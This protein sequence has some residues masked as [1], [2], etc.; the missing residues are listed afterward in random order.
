[1]QLT[2]PEPRGRDGICKSVDDIL[3]ATPTPGQLEEKIEA[4]LKVCLK[5]S[6][7]LSPSKFQCAC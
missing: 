2:K 6:L 4:E 7:K 1:M 3:T 5:K